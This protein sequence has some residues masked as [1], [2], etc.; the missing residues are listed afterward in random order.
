MADLDKLRAHLSQ[1]TTLGNSDDA[2]TVQSAINDIYA[3]H[4]RPALTELAQITTRPPVRIRTGNRPRQNRLKVNDRPASVRRTT[5]VT[6]LAETGLRVSGHVDTLYGHDTKNNPTIEFKDIRLEHALGNVHVTIAEDDAAPTPLGDGSSME[7]G[8][9]Q[10]RIRR[11]LLNHFKVDASPRALLEPPI[12]TDASSGRRQRPA[13][14]E[15]PSPSQKLDARSLP[16]VVLDPIVREEAATAARRLALNTPLQ[17]D[18]K[19]ENT[20]I[21]EALAAVAELLDLDDLNRD[22]TTVL[23]HHYALDSMSD[24]ATQVKQIV[25]ESLAH[26]DPTTALSVAEDFVDRLGPARYTPDETAL[27]AL[28]FYADALE[29]SGQSHL[30]AEVL[31]ER[32]TM[33]NRLNIQPSAAETLRIARDFRFGDDPKAALRL[34][35]EMP[36]PTDTE[37][38]ARQRHEAAMS[39]LAIDQADLAVDVAEQA[40]DVVRSAFQNGPAVTKAYACAMYLEQFAQFVE[41]DQ[42]DQAERVGLD[43]IAQIDPAKDFQ[44]NISNLQSPGRIAAEMLNELS[45]EEEEAEI[46]LHL[47]SAFEAISDG[48]PRFGDEGLL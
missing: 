25:D 35:H 43:L 27:T 36:A 8:A 24:E 42:L 37:N 15:Q 14:A 47:Q 13:I 41:V 34:I 44:P 40:R 23:D 10:D 16:P 19:G 38:A 48:A 32:R 21:F 17:R 4:A 29:A 3:F 26:H 7:M 6:W 11:N 28:G 33:L 5:E 39:Y 9:L 1:V 22:I 45:G 31:M 46:K 12:F 2:R 18:A 20:K 30:A